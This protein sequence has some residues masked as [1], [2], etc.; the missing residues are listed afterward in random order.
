M[1]FPQSV[2]ERTRTCAKVLDVGGSYIPLPTAT[3]IL[4]LV[5][6][7]EPTQATYVEHDI[8]V[9]PWPFPD[10][11]FD[12][13]FCSNTLEDIRDPIGACKELMRV[14]RAGYIEVPSRLRETFHPKGAFWWRRMLGRPLRIGFGHHRWFVER[15]DLHLFGRAFHHGLGGRPPTHAGGVDPRLHLGERIPGRGA[16]ADRRRRDR[17]G[18]HPLQDRGAAEAARTLSAPSFYGSMRNSAAVAFQI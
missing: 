16:R 8:C 10:K 12:F 5:P 14:S 7:R 2:L 18:L 11:F 3:H 4:D 6:P 17:G 1:S 9:P 15:R 13:S